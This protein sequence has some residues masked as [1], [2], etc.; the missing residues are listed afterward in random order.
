MVY[1]ALR[2]GIERSSA[3]VGVPFRLFQHIRTEAHTWL[4]R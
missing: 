2:R 4:V 3:R 1:Q